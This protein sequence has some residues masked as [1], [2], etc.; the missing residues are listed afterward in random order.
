[1]S[2]HVDDFLVIGTNP[3]PIIEAFKKNF[4]MMH[5]EINTTSY[6]GL[7]WE[8]S[9]LGSSKIHNEKHSKETISQVEKC[10]GIKLKKEN[11]P[12]H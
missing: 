1:M 4:D 10:L 9:E 8:H 6:L 5:E 11:A 12:I 2:T 7:Q 3:D